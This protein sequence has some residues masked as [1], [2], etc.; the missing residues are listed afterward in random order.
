MKKLEKKLNKF[1]ESLIGLEEKP[2][3]LSMLEQMNWYKDHYHAW[4]VEEVEKMLAHITGS[5][6]QLDWVKSILR[7]YMSSIY[8]NGVD[9]TFWALYYKA[10]V[11]ASMLHTEASWWIQHRDSLKDT[12]S[13]T[14][15]VEEAK[16]KIQ[17]LDEDDS[18]I[19][20]YDKEKIGRAHV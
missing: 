8:Q 1:V 19:W 4:A 16:E 3:D 5:E 13:H 10:A 11:Q 15:E 2:E 14:T 17:S 6:K 7:S 9:Y 20:D 18:L 12:F